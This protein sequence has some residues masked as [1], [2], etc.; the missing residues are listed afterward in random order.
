VH[1]WLLLLLLLLLLVTKAVMQLGVLLLL[2][3]RGPEGAG[4]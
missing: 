2:C 1:L 4:W 3:R